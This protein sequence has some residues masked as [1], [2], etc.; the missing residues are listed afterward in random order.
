MVSPE[1]QVRNL[2]YK[3]EISAHPVFR[4]NGGV[5][6][7]QGEILLRVGCMLQKVL[8]FHGNPF[9]YGILAIL[10]EFKFSPSSVGN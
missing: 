8:R 9:P 1:G 4:E 6:R 2:R 7:V 5:Q 10:Y 3:T